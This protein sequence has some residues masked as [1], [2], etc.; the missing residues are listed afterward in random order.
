MRQKLYAPSLSNDFVPKDSFG[1]DDYIVAPSASCVGFVRNY[2]SKLFDNSSLHNEV[3]ELSKRTYEFSEFMVKV[4][5]VYNV[6]AKLEGKAT[7]HDSCAGLR[8]CKIKAGA[9]ETSCQC[10]RS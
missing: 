8:E 4:L 2:Y 3:K 9:E 10:K 6:G 1:D 5:Q 7:Y